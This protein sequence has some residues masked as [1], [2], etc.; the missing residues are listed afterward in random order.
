MA[1]LKQRMID[2]MN[3]RG[4]S[5]HTVVAYLRSVQDLANFHR[6]SPAALNRDQIRQY[7]L[8]MI[9][10]RRLAA[11]SVN[12]AH[13]AIT[14]FYAQVLGRRHFPDLPKVKGDAT[15]PTVLSL[16][17]VR[18]LFDATPNLKHRTIL[19]TIYSA[20]L[21]VGELINLRTTDVSS[22]RM[23]IFIRR[24]KGRKDRY[25]ILSHTNLEQL[26]AYYREYRPAD[27]LFYSERG[28]D[29]RYSCR[30]IGYI[31]KQS[32]RRAGIGRRVMTHALRHSFATHMLETGVQLPV[33]QRLMGHSS[34]R[35][36]G[37]YLHVSR[38]D[39]QANSG[40]LD[41][42]TNTPP[43]FSGDGSHDRDTE[44]TNH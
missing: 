16:E 19:M 29:L 14:F 25:A 30:S 11:S 23:Q 44:N 37:I 38:A 33:L 21:R 18:R 40:P 36:T 5:P 20:G 6:C 7:L 9:R 8:H 28:K 35:T 39:L 31:V 43:G 1:M 12:L 15:K 3:L 26:R 10:E 27:W 2:E 17:E 24:S 4:F 13:S 34:L 22:Q 41:L 42:I 32:A